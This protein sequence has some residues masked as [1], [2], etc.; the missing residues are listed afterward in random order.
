MIVKDSSKL[1]ISQ[2]ILLQIPCKL[3][4]LIII[5]DDVCGTIADIVVEG[6]TTLFRTDCG[7]AGK[8]GTNCVGWIITWGNCPLCEMLLTLVLGATR[9]VCVN[10]ILSFCKT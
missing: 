6:W 5:C 7:V 3:S 2:L 4:C 8:T 1:D 10:W 9:M